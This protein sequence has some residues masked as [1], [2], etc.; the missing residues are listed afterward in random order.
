MKVSIIP[1]ATTAAQ[2]SA[3]QYISRS[4]TKEGLVLSCGVT[5]P[6]ITV[7]FISFCFLSRILVGFHLPFSLPCSL[8]LR[9]VTAPLLGMLRNNSLPEIPSM[10]HRGGLPRPTHA[11]FFFRRAHY[12]HSTSKVKAT[13]LF[14][15]F[16]V[17]GR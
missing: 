2:R 15:F 10:L 1:A 12:V 7:F 16:C 6:C 14:L 4:S 17:F 13:Y 11:Q 8:E 5:I 3:V 9:R